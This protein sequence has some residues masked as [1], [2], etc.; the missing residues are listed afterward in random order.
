MK[1]ILFLFSFILS[2]FLLNAQPCKLVKKGM[3]QEQ[4]TQ[5]VGTPSEVNHLGADILKDGNKVQL[6]VW[7]YGDPKED[8]NQRV[9]FSDGIVTEIV[10]DGKKYDILLAQVRIGK[11]SEAELSEQIEKMNAEGCR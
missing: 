9:F 8:G 5:A 2:G 10:S 11:I 1:K 4:V 6:V 7:Q 3:T